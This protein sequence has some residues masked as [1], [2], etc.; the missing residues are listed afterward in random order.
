MYRVIQRVSSLAGQQG[1]LH[2]DYLLQSILR[3]P[4]LSR[5]PATVEEL[6]HLGVLCG[7]RHSPR[8]SLGGEAAVREIEDR[9]K[10]GLKQE[11]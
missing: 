8:I 6:D 3:K 10:E 5:V 9:R 2:L 1:V 4:I 11:R 7:W